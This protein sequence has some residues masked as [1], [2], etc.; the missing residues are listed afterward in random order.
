MRGKTARRDKPQ[1]WAIQQL[2]DAGLT[3]CPFSSMPLADVGKP[4]RE[5]VDAAFWAML[6][7]AVGAH[8]S[9]ATAADRE[10]A[11]DSHAAYV[12]SLEAE[13]AHA[14][15]EPQA[16]DRRTCAQ[17]DQ[18]Q[19]RRILEPL[20]LKHS[21]E[22]G[23]QPINDLLE[24]YSDAY[25]PLDGHNIVVVPKLMQKLDMDPVKVQQD[26]IDKYPIRKGSES[27]ERGGVQ[28]VA[29]NHKSLHYRG[30]ELAREKMWFQREETWTG[31][32]PKI[33][34]YYYTGVQWAVV[35]AQSCWSKCAEVQGV[36]DKMDALYERINAPS[37]NHVIVTRYRGEVK[38]GIGPHFDK[39]Q[40]IAPNSLITILKTGPTG[41]T[42]NLYQGE[43]SSNGSETPTWSRV[44]NPGDA[45]IMTLGANC[46]TKH[47]VPIDDPAQCG[48]AGSLCLRTVSEKTCEEVERHQAASE[49]AKQRARDR[50]RTPG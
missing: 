17:M 4:G 19:S 3:V 11:S 40:S 44:L 6:V 41:R 48:D 7:D 5:E 9:G 16:V 43:P 28:W 24:L 23:I 34:Y 32:A 18:D 8:E 13:A 33:N 49:R 31:P 42:F 50:R 35:N 22:M 2:R 30:N 25:R 39:P 12:K 45:L 21:D 1:L 27:I 26:L 20:D 15:V 14:D 38:S 29:G 37:A 36:M 47:G 10:R 46:A